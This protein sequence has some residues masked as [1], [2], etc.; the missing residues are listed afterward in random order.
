MAETKVVEAW[1][2]RLEAVMRDAPK[3][4][5][6]Y[7]ANGTAHVMRLGPDGKR[8]VKR[9]RVTFDQNAIV[10]TLSGIR[11]AMDGGDW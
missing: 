9:D 7:V 8:I 6:L 3:G 11:I 2:K 4:C 5:W 10:Y 1:A